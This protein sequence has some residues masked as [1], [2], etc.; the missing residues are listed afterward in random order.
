MCTFYDMRTR[1]GMCQRHVCALLEV[2]G[3]VIIYYNQNGKPG[4]AGIAW[5]KYENITEIRSCIRSHIL[6][7]LSGNPEQGPILAR[8]MLDLCLLECTLMDS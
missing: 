7:L 6:Q 3:E 5:N 1:T 8:S 2:I 4:Q